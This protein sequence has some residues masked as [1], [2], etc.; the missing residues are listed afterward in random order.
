MAPPPNLSLAHIMWALSPWVP[1]RTGGF[2]LYLR[3]LSSPDIR[4]EAGGSCHSE[5]CGGGQR[6]WKS[7]WLE[8]ESNSQLEWVLLLPAC[9]RKARMLRR[10]YLATIRRGDLGCEQRT[11]HYVRRL[12]S[13]S[14]RGHLG[15]IVTSRAP[16]AAS[17]RT[18]RL[19]R[20][21]IRSTSGAELHDRRR[22]TAPRARGAAYLSVGCWP[23]GETT[24]TVSPKLVRNTR[25]SASP[26]SQSL[27][28]G[29]RPSF[30]SSVR[31]FGARVLRRRGVPAP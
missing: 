24:P 15:V 20:N 2:C 11:A 9:C 30:A 31:P 4:E 8:L 14:C 6:R 16:A 10:G 28:A 19:H 17:Q 5:W 21:P 1:R 25:S 12:Q 13:T 23:V 7:N 26:E 29:R 18:E 22:S 27:P 3:S